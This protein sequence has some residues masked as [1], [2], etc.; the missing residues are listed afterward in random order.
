VV[1]GVAVLAA[2]WPVALLVL[3]DPRTWRAWV[4]A[5]VTLIL[6]CVAAYSSVELLLGRRRD[7][8]PA[9]QT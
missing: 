2:A 1:I 8:L 5:L 7:G 9:Q 6:A 3:N 4:T